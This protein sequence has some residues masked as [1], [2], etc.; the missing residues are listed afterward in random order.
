MAE[1]TDNRYHY[2]WIKH[3]N[4]KSWDYYYYSPGITKAQAKEILKQDSSI[5]DYELT[6]S[7]DGMGW[8]VQK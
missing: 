6:N 2:L 5:V 1:N 3:K 7:N 8:P 4:D